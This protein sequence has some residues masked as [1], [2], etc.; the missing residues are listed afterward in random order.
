MTSHPN[1]TCGIIPAH[2]VILSSCSH[3]RNPIL[4]SR[5]NSNNHNFQYFSTIFEASPGQTAN[6]LIYVILPPE[7]TKRALE[8][9]VQYIYCGEATVHNDVLNEVLKGGEILKIRGL[10]RGSSSDYID[11]H[12]HQRSFPQPPTHPS[13]SSGREARIQIAYERERPVVIR[14]PEERSPARDPAISNSS[15]ANINSRSSVYYPSSSVYVKKD[16]GRDPGNSGDCETCRITLQSSDANKDAHPSTQMPIEATAA[17]AAPHQP[18][19]DQQRFISSP[20]STF[21]ASL[22]SQPKIIKTFY[23]SKTIVSDPVDPSTSID[24]PFRQHPERERERGIIH[25]T[26]NHSSGAFANPLRPPQLTSETPN[27][28]IIGPI[29]QEPPDWADEYEQ[30]PQVEVPVKREVIYN[31]ERQAGSGG[32]EVVSCGAPM[33]TPLSCELCKETF[34]QPGEW[35]RHI[36]NHAELPQTVP[37]KRRRTEVRVK[38]G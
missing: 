17:A 30:K 27:E 10:W 25:H 38:R 9:L 11:N 2:K 13:T 15:A 37:K 28:N 36:E 29:K 31:E 22:Q 24:R 32:D 18:L 23:P 16:M 8:I 4:K 34:T 14:N 6:S 26:P 3:V 1:E 12:Y 7:L 35:V 5:I 21:R 19:M 33:Y 20:E